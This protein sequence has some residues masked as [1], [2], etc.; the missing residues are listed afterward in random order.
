MTTRIETNNKDGY[1]RR[2]TKI[3]KNII[4]VF[5]D[6][7]WRSTSG[8]SRDRV[9]VGWSDSE[10]NRYHVWLE[11]VGSLE[12]ALFVEGPYLYK[13]ESFV[14]KNP[15]LGAKSGAEGY[16]AT[17]HLDPDSN[18]WKASLALI[19]ERVR[20]GNMISCAFEAYDANEAAEKAQAEIDAKVQLLDRASKALAEI[21]C[22]KWFNEGYT[23][24]GFFAS[25][26][27]LQSLAEYFTDQTVALS[28]AK[29]S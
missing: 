4:D 27:S 14:Y 3:E 13:V 15:P 7:S 9:S 5:V 25:R 10:G 17:R 8:G 29:N 6:V 19:A 22:S 28:A 21:G 18:V 16:F 23:E 12:E 20:Q 11:N 26:E 2:L 24:S 1:T